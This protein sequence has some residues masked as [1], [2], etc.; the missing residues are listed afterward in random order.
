MGLRV[1]RARAKYNV[2]APATTG[3]ADFERYFRVQANTLEW[4]PIFLG[5]LWLFAIYWSDLVAAA[6]GLVWIIGRFLYMTGY[7][8]AAEAREAGFMIQALASAVLVFGALGRL[9]W[10]AVAGG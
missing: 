3:Q 7:S 8:K 1:G 10:L 9:I 5:S 6:I 2:P 4:L